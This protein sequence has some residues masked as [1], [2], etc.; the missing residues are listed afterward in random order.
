MTMKLYALPGVTV[1]LALVL[2]ACSTPALRGAWYYQSDDWNDKEVLLLTLVNHSDKTFEIS[3][4]EVNAASTGEQADWTCN[5]AGA[6]A[7]SWSMRSGQLLVLQLPIGNA[8]CAVPA[9]VKVRSD[10]KAIDVELSTS[11]PSALPKVWRDCPVP[12]PKKE[13]PK[14]SAKAA[15]PS[16]WV[17]PWLPQQPP[18]PPPPPPWSC[19]KS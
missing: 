11:M 15:S 14:Q 8:P 4:V 9:R 5:Y 17:P 13:P 3:S 1:V 19:G 12:G 2:S 16:P 6:G 10:G 18:P 7:P